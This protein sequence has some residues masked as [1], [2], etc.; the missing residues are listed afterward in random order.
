MPLRSRALRRLA[1]LWVIL[2]LVALTAGVAAAT[3]SAAS[4][5]QFTTPYSQ[6][7]TS[8]SSVEI[9]G[10]I[11]LL[12]GY[13]Y[14]EATETLSIYHD[15]QWAG[16]GAGGNVVG[17]WHE[18]TP[19]TTERLGQAAVAYNHFIYVLGGGNGFES[20]YN[21]V[22]YAEVG[23]S[24]NITPAGWHATSS[25]NIPRAA[26]SANVTVI[27]GRPYIYAIGGAGSKPN[28]ETIHFANVEYAEIHANGSLGAWTISPNEFAKPRSS[29][30]TAIVGGCLY[31]V[32]GF[33]EA[34]TEVLG[35]VQYSC[36][37]SNGSVKPWT[38]SPNS[39]HD[40]RFGAEMVVVPGSTPK[41]VVIGGDAGEGTYLNEIESTNVYGRFGNSP[42]KVAPESAFLPQ[43]QW[44][45]TGVLLNGKV[46]VL[47]GVLRDQEYLDQAIFAPVS[48]LL[49]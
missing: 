26:L 45:Q 6:G 28:G 37:N 7:R 48:A 5:W 11:Y 43:G 19:F 32:G 29:M 12:G 4:P 35:E 46:Y 31:V 2:C 18:T 30:T 34:F 14:N 13:S 47:G 27:G 20:Y 44:G 17:G 42:W 39:M 24:G 25:L 10:R 41:F 1:G 33:G 38:L 21:T 49:D 22:E 3:A 16:V 8:A 40:V 15:V 23:P 36:I 9:G